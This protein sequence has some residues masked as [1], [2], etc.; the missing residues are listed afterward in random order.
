MSMRR[1]V[2]VLLGALVL[3]LGASPASAEQR[4][5]DWREREAAGEVRE[6][7]EATETPL[8]LDDIEALEELGPAPGC[9]FAGSATRG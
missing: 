3:G 8:A 7:L 5:P 1:K 6:A 9:R 4:A 2:V